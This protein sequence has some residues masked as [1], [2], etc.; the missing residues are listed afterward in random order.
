M[1]YSAHRAH[2]HREHT[3]ALQTGLAVCHPSHRSA[4]SFRF[5]AAIRWIACARKSGAGVTLRSCPISGSG[6][7]K[8]SEQAAN[9]FGRK[10]HHRD[11]AGVVEAGRSDDAKDA[12]H[13]ALLVLEWSD[14]ERRSR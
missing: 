6:G 13:L 4:S 3:V 5:L 9:E 7:K 14:D 12:H 2:L 11:D 1:P 10:I 8:S